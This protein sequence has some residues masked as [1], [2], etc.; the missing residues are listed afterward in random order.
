[1]GEMDIVQG[2]FEDKINS[3]YQHEIKMAVQYESQELWKD[4]QET[5]RKVANELQS[6]LHEEF[7]YQAYYKVKY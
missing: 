5:Y 4:A 7:V 6:A 1:M 2:I 3:G